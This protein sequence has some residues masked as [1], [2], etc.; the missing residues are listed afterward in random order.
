MT[1]TI[2]LT[3]RQSCVI[4]DIDADLADFKWFAHP[5]GDNFYARRSKDENPHRHMILHRIVLERILGR[6]LTKKELVDHIDGNTLNNRRS[7]L[8]LASASQNSKNR[9]RQKNNHSGYKGV[10]WHAKNRCWCAYIHV[11]KKSHYLGSFADPVSAHKAYK[12]AAIKYF[13]EFVRDE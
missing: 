10:S 11:D 13:G 6:S 2:T 5:S 12:Q 3:R 9:K 8:R 1:I 7:N 4:D